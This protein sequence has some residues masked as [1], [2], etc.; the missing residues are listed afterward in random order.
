M[1]VILAIKYIFVARPETE[2]NVNYQ[3]NIENCTFFI[4]KSRYV[5][6]SLFISGIKILCAGS[7]HLMCKF[8]SQMCLFVAHMK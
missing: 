3:E 6:L 1:Y 2:L 8:L 7:D 4:H 5:V